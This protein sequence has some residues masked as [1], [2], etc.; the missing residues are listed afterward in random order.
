MLTKTATDY[1]GSRLKIARMLNLTKSAVYQWG[2]VVP[3]AS[4]ENLEKLA[5]ATI[6]VDEALYNPKTFHP[7]Y[8]A[9]DKNTTTSA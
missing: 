1:F 4:A 9:R 2:R 8:P 5:G 3:K 6:R 7:I